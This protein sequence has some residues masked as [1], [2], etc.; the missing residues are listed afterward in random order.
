ML[1]IILQSDE[2][3]AD[4]MIFLPYCLQKN[5]VAFAKTLSQNFL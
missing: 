1:N 2:H 3:M 5:F 4:I